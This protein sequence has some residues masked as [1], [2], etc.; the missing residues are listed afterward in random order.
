MD[1]KRERAH[2]R[3]PCFGLIALAL[4]I[5]P[6]KIIYFFKYARNFRHNGVDCI[7]LGDRV[8]EYHPSSRLYIVTEMRNPHFSPEVAVKVTLLNFMITPE[9]LQV[10]NESLVLVYG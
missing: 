2:S 10:R 1:R 4:C 8:V 5:F 7:F 9:G 6:K 3:N